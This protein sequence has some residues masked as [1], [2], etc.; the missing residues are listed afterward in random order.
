MQK[1]QKRAAICSE[2]ARLLRSQRERANLSMTALAAK[3]GLSQQMVSYVEKGK[4]NPTLDT[5]L[6]L[7]HALEIPLASLIAKAE[8]HR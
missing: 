1:A 2:V 4:R 6:R 8:K 3:T 5:L 7:A